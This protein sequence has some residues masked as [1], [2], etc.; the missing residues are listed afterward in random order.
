M[1]EADPIIAA[2]TIEAGL[3]APARDQAGAEVGEQD[4]AGRTLPPP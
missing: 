1:A 4:G 2:T 3:V